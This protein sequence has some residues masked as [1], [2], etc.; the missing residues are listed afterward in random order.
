MHGRFWRF[1]P[2]AL[3]N[4]LHHRR[5]HHIVED[6]NR[7]A[8]LDKLV[9]AEMFPSSEMKPYWNHLR[10]R[11]L[12]RFCN[13]GSR[14]K[15]PHRSGFE[16]NHV[17]IAVTGALGEKH[18]SK[19]VCNAARKSEEGPSVEVQC[20]LFGASSSQQFGFP[21]HG[22][23]RQATR[24]PT[25][26]WARDQIVPCTNDEFFWMIEENGQRIH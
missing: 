16:P 14:Q 22:L 18:A 23:D 10:K 4:S 9:R 8:K 5:G 26:K 19:A 11:H 7:F 13:S 6:F 20:F 15:G 25:Q 2:P 21:H 1:N 17:G 12:L 3:L 24:P